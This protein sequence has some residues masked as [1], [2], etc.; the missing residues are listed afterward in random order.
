MMKRVKRAIKAAVGMEYRPKLDVELETVRL[1][2]DY[3]GWDVVADSLDAGSVVYS[4]GVGEDASFDL[5]VIEKFGATVHAFDPTPRSI[6]W[7]KGQE[8]PEKFVLHEYGIAD[9]D[10]EVTFHPPENPE[11]VSHT[12]LGARSPDGK[13]IEVPVKRL[14]TI[15]GEL[16]HGSIDVLKMDVEGAEYAVIED[17][18]QTEVRPGQILVEFHHRFPGVGLEKTKRAVGQLREMGYLLASV[19]DSAEEFGF[20]M[21]GEER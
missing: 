8:L 15:M 19:S 13:A 2:S 10:G 1:G 20:V 14:A 21:R 12:L 16:G 3:G 4:F 5:A 11:H 6:E 18:S 17:I 7:V 9:V